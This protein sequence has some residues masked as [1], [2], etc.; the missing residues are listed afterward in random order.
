MGKCRNKKKLTVI[1]M[2]LI[3]SLS[4]GLPCE[5]FAMAAPNPGSETSVK[6]SPFV[7]QGTDFADSK[8][9]IPKTGT[10]DGPS[11][12]KAIP[13]I[14]LPGNYKSTKTVLGFFGCSK[15]PK[16]ILERHTGDRYY[17]GTKYRGLNSAHK[18]YYFTV[19]N[20]RDGKG[21]HMNCT[22]F[23]ASV[24]RSC[25]GDLSKVNKY[26]RRPD[27]KG[28]YANAS[29]WYY[30]LHN[31]GV[32]C[33]KYYSVSAAK[34]AARKGKFKK[35]DI[36]YYEPRK[37]GHG[38]DCHITFYWGGTKQWESTDPRNTIKTMEGAARKCWVYVFPVTVRGKLR[39]DKDLSGS[40]PADI[41]R[42]GV[43]RLKGAVYG[44][45]DSRAKAK[46]ATNRKRGDYVRILRT[47]NRKG[48]SRKISLKAGRYYIKE[49]KAS[50]GMKLNKAVWSVRVKPKKTAV[51]EVTGRISSAARFHMLTKVDGDTG[52]PLS[53]AVFKVTYYQSY[54][55]AATKYKKRVW[56]LKS[57]SKGRVL[58]NKAHMAT[59]GKYKGMSS[60]MFSRLPLGR[61]VAVEVQAPYGYEI[62]TK[63]YIKTLTS[64]EQLG[65]KLKMPRAGR[66][67]GRVHEEEEPEDPGETL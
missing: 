56:Y 46:A 66:S 39:I 26:A 18:P 62:T 1:I 28:A 10:K 16:T 38:A 42:L 59:A 6:G 47:V 35:G 23:G 55:S 19:P 61:Y 21:G 32:R 41:R 64:Q 31:A 24:I 65:K 67:E 33:L 53:G 13:H 30:A 11:P 12:Q 15:D 22:G 44:V 43:Y 14:E 5:S 20:G 54:R 7:S 58:I 48:L 4:L 36:I 50:K 57:D 25:G 37:W 40:A 8:A 3:I 2:S 34:R 52:A 45:Y 17:L 49:L 27:L 29:K 9:S 63:K 51:K 60:K